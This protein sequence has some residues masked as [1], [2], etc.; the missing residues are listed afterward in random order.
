[1]RSLQTIRPDFQSGNEHITALL[2]IGTDHRRCT[3]TLV[4]PSQLCGLLPWSP[5]FTSLSRFV[6]AE[7]GGLLLPAFQEP[8]GSDSGNCIPQRVQ[9][10][11]KIPV[12][13]LET[14]NSNKTHNSN[15]H[16]HPP[17]PGLHN[18]QCHPQSPSF[19]W[20]QSLL[21]LGRVIRI[22]PPFLS[23]HRKWKPGVSS[24]GQVGPSKT[25]P[26]LAGPAEGVEEIRQV[27][28]DSHSILIFF[29]FLMQV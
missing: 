18:S 24:E 27:F 14:Q 22:Q 4:L 10:N 23:S 28:I 13:W 25:C 20:G 2:R 6:C 21:Y 17:I 29:L 16:T 5:A 26:D 12:Q 9:M 15:T 3:P 1:M 8:C 11:F 19:A 7:L